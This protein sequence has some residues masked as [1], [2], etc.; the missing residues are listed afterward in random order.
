MMKLEKEESEKVLKSVKSETAIHKKG[1]ISTDLIRL[2]RKLD[3][4]IIMDRIRSDKRNNFIRIKAHQYELKGDIE[5][6]KMETLEYNRKK[7]L[8]V[9]FRTKVSKLNLQKYREKISQS[10]NDRVK[11]QK[12]EEKHIAEI[13]KK[14][15]RKLEKIANAEM[16]IFM[17]SKFQ[18][19][20]TKVVYNEMLERSAQEHH[21]KIQKIK[22]ESKL[23]QSR[24]LKMSQSQAHM[25]SGYT[26][27]SFNDPNKSQTGKGRHQVIC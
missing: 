17:E 8:D 1:Y 10:T 6:R 2:K 14:K 9:Q 16:E 27:Q 3:H 5:A 12:E 25:Q 19:E 20:E 7:M 23:N 15:V 4:E 13:T 26:E 22:S 21:A 18:E 11:N 24:L